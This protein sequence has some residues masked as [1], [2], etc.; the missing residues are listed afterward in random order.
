VA[1]PGLTPER[2]A[3]LRAAF[4]ATVKDPLL[5]E[6]ASKGRNNIRFTGASHMEEIVAQVYAT[7]P[8]LVQTVRSLMAQ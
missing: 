8:A 1:P 3:T 6:E 4:E 7:D 2:L 5:L